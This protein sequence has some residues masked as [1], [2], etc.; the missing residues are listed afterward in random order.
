VREAANAPGP[1]RD[2][3]EAGFTLLE[4]LVAMA[5][6]GLAV[7]TLLQLTSQSVRL[8]YRSGEQQRAIMLADRVL[9][10]AD[11]AGEGVEEGT[12]GP[13]VWQRRATAVPVSSE[14]A[15]TTGPV[16]LLL[17]VTVDVRWGTRAVQLSSLRALLP[18]RTL[19]RT[20]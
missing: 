16:P 1:I 19:P 6:L 17:A 3:R 7:T 13:F 5:I 10:Q 8:L 20:P 9:R 15:P 11:L 2:S 4:V 14:L 12:E 18:E